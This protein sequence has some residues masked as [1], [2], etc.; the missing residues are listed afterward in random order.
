MIIIIVDQSISTI[1][2]MNSTMGALHWD[3]D[4]NL[5]SPYQPQSRKIRAY[6]GFD[7]CMR[8]KNSPTREKQCK[9]SDMKNSEQ[10]SKLN[11]KIIIGSHKISCIYK[12]YPL[13]AERPFI[14]VISLKTTKQRSSKDIFTLIKIIMQISIWLALWEQKVKTKTFYLKK[15]SIACGL[16]ILLLE[17]YEKKII[18]K[19]V[20]PSAYYIPNTC[21]SAWLENN[22]YT[23]HVLWVRYFVAFDK[24]SGSQ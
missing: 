24:K 2:Q 15:D 22:N 11:S 19:R 1:F 3:N 12:T 5:F 10:Y 17:R 20:Y 21:S 16:Y 14:I 7:A 4:Q 9:N 23:Y 8:P 18:Y 6:I 13:P